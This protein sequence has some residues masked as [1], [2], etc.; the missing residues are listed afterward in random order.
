MRK[1]FKTECDLL[2]LLL[3][4]LNRIVCE[5]SFT[6]ALIENP[7]LGCHSVFINDSLPQGNERN[8]SRSANIS[9][10]LNVGLPVW[11]DAM[12]TPS[13]ISRNASFSLWSEDNFLRLLVNMADISPNVTVLSG[14]INSFR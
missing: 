11:F 9:T 12:R 10:Y 7:F 14:P 5:L 8:F 13:P 6:C 3:Q 1:T 2:K 4:I